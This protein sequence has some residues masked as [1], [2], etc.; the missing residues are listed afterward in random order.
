MDPECAPA[1]AEVKQKKKKSEDDDVPADKRVRVAVRIRP[2]NKADHG[3][4]AVCINVENNKI[5]VANEERSSN[6]TYDH[7]FQGTQA[8]V[9]ASVGEQMLQDAFSGYNTTI[10]AYGQTGSGKTYSM[11]GVQDDPDH[12]G[13]LPRI[14]QELFELSQ[15]LMSEDP[16]L[17]IKIQVSFVEIYNEKIRDLL[18]FEGSGRPT[19][20]DASELRD[21]KLKEDKKHRCFFVD[22]LSMHTVMNLTRIQKLLQDGSALRTHALTGMNDISSRSHSVF[23]IYLSQV[24]EP[25]SVMD[26]D[27]ASKITIVDLAGSERQSKTE[28]SDAKRMKEAER[29]NMSLLILGRCLSAC[30]DPK[31]GSHIPIRDSVLTKMLSDIFGGNSKTLMF[32]TVSPS[33]F[34][35]GES[36]STLQYAYN[37]KKIKHKAVVNNLSKAIEIAELKEQVKALGRTLVEELEKAAQQKEMLDKEIVAITEERELVA[38]ALKTCQQ[39]NNLLKQQL[40]ELLAEKERLLAGGAIAP[41]VPARRKKIVKRRAPRAAAVDSGLDSSDAAPAE[42]VDDDDRAKERKLAEIHAELSRKLHLV[43]PMITQMHKARGQ[44]DSSARSD[45]STRS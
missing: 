39:E 34:N 11:L 40:E 29:I 14:C 6:F 5:T 33:M 43:N 32:A 38:S 12:M 42:V 36:L 28:N 37:A 1:P 4:T 41:V 31:Q 44:L 20:T 19:P 25:P 22:E 21:L 24:H 16:S 3:D 23:T 17:I 10:F 9:Y 35:Y 8:E 13:L 45:V 18:E 7:V 30:S 2:F 27:R 26:R 15:E